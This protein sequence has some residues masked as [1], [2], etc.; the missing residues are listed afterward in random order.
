MTICI[1][2]DCRDEIGR[3]NQLRERNY[4]TK[5]EKRGLG[6]SNLEDILRKENHIYHEMQIIE[7]KF[8]QR[9]EIKDLL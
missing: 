6:I 5:G 4:S 8:I 1:Q 9:L 3:V 7:G 2:N